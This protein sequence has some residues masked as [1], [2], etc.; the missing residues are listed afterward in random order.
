MQIN[1]CDTSYKWIEGYPFIEPRTQNLMRINIFVNKLSKWRVLLRLLQDFFFFL[2]FLWL[3][4]DFFPPL[5]IIQQHLKL[6]SVKIHFTLEWC[7]ITY[8]IP[9]PSPYEYVLSSEVDGKIWLR[10]VSPPVSWNSQHI[11]CCRGEIFFLIVL[12]AD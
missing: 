11:F 3:L 4:Q 8:H 1:Q 9:F 12:H 2:L 10:N 5:I 6:K 7:S